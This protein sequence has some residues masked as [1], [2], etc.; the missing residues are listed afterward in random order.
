MPMLKLVPTLSVDDMDKTVA[1][2]RDV[3]EPMNERRRLRMKSP[4]RG[5]RLDIASA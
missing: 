1:F 2:Y 3:L 4:L 5:W